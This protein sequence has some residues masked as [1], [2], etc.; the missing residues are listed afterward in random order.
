MFRLMQGADYEDL[1]SDIRANG[2]R[3]P[4]WTFQGKIIDG[5]NRAR[6]CQDLGVEPATREWDGGGSLVAFVVSL[7]LHRRHLTSSQR[8]AAAAEMLPMLEREAK[9]RQRTHGGTAPG[10]KTLGQ[11]ADGVKGKASQQAARLAGTNRQYVAEAK[12][13][14]EQAPDLF[15]QVR[16]GKLRVAQAR[17]E[18]KRRVR[19]AEAREAAQAAAR[20]QPAGAT[21]AGWK[22]SGPWCA[23]PQNSPRASKRFA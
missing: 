15:E 22:S 7:N 4:V 9:E 1:K 19:N 3:E 11:K 10:R 5:R 14:R 16:D 8:A 21:R 17:E 6:A 13:I 2:L 12:R 23:L 20:E 18:L